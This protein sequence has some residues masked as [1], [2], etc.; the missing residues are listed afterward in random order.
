MVRVVDTRTGSTVLASSKQLAEGSDQVVRATESGNPQGREQCWVGAVSSAAAKVQPCAPQ[1]GEFP[2]LCC[3][4]SYTLKTTISLL[5][6]LLVD[7][8]SERNALI[9]L[10]SYQI[11]STERLDL[12]FAYS[13]TWLFPTGTRFG[14]MSLIR[15]RFRQA[16]SV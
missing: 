4:G 9:H 13:P 5:A 8:D 12:G 2:I 1:C 11:S 3:V 7:V 15:I 6:V 14:W 10:M 16:F